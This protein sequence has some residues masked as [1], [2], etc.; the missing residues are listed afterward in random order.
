M[1]LG[2]DPD[3]T[4]IEDRIAHSWELA[5]PERLLEAGGR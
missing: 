4:L 3:W 5:A 1:T 2:G